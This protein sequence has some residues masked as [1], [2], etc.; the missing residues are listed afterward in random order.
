MKKEIVEYA[1]S[2]T[3][4][5]PIEEIAKVVENIEELEYLIKAIGTSDE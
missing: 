1:K 4:D 3:Q 5:T 2:I